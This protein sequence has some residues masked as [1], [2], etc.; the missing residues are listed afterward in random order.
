MKKGEIGGVVEFED[1]GKFV[2][3]CCYPSSML[4]PLN[5]NTSLQPP[6]CELVVVDMNKKVT[7]WIENDV[8]ESFNFLGQIDKVVP[9]LF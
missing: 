9:I 8:F 7:K 4:T 6:F 1:N 3:Q 2:F 5:I